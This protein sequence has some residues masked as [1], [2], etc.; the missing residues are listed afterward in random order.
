MRKVWFITGCSTGFGRLLAERLIAMGEA[1]AATAQ[2]VKDLRDLEAESED[3]LLTLQADVTNSKQ[4]RKAV[5][6]AIKKFD[7]IDVLVNNAGY[8]YFATQEES[9]IE[10]VRNVFDTNVLGFVRTVEH[11]VPHMRAQGGGCVVVIL[12]PDRVD[13]HQAFEPLRP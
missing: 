10:E 9:D 5:E 1:V 2:K 11:V 4:V 3:M 12:L 8:G 7:R 13:G 6:A